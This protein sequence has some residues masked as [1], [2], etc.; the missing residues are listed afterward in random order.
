MTDFVYKPSSID[1]SATFA[2][3]KVQFGDGYV[4]RTPSGINNAL[5]RWSV[6]FTDKSKADTDAMV[7]F[8]KARFGAT[9]FSW[10]PTGETTDVRVVC[11]SWSKPIQNRYLAGEFVY[12]VTA[13]FQETPI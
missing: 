8:W 12:N 7:A 2:V 3:D 9:S 13:T 10:R 4:Q 6:T 5:R 11:E 1:E